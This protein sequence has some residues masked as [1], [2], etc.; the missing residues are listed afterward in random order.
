MKRKVLTKTFMMISNLLVSWF[1]IYRYFS[2]LRVNPFSAGTVFMR[3][4]LTYKVNPRTEKLKLFLTANE[5]VR[6]N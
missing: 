5:V 3:Q 1:N 6:A 4:I 2:A